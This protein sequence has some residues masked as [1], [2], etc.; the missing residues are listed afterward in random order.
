MCVYQ[1]L[2]H[3]LYLGDEVGEE[4]RHVLLLPGVERLLVHGV[5]FTEGPG[6]IRFP[7]TLLNRQRRMLKG[8]ESLDD[9]TAVWS[10][11]THS[12]VIKPSA[13]CTS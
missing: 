12:I 2:G 3:L 11:Q 8:S 1:L 9:A 7:L 6:V 13:E 4:L 10:I 5:G